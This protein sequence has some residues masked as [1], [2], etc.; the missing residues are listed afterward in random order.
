MD[1]L[2][3]REA[4]VRAARIHGQIASDARRISRLHSVLDRYRMD[5]GPDPLG[6]SHAQRAYEYKLISAQA[7]IEMIERRLA[8]ARHD[9]DEADAAERAALDAASA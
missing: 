7:E 2:F 6:N 8:V 3:W 4:A 9:A 5:E 1:S